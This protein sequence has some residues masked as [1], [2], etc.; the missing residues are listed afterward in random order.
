MSV[1]RWIKLIGKPMENKHGH[2]FVITDFDSDKQIFRI[3]FED[4][5]IVNRVTDEM[6]KNNATISPMLP[7]I[8]GVGYKG[9][10]ENR[11]YVGNYATPEYKSWKDMLR[12]CYSEE[13]LSKHKSYIGC[14]VCEEWHNFQNYAKWY[15]ENYYELG[16]RMN[17]DKDILVK[18]NKV[19][20]PETCVFVDDRINKLFIKSDASR[21]EY[22]VGV[23]KTRSN[24]FSVHCC[25]YNEPDKHKLFDTPEEAFYEYKRRKEMIIKRVANEYKDMIPEKL[26]NAMMNYEVEITD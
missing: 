7:T 14:L 15:H 11:F 26:Y 1:G 19:Y 16:R 23:Y 9:N 8:Y 22:Y 5:G 2:K 12:R 24:R 25:D 17:L 21:S 4:G 6:L 10:G 20:S 3:V 18:H 13:C